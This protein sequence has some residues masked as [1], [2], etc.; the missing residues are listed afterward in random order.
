MSKKSFYYQ[1]IKKIAQV[2]NQTYPIWRTSTIQ[3]LKSFH[4]QQIKNKQENLT[5]LETRARIRLLRNKPFLQQIREQNDYFNI[6]FTPTGDRDEDVEKLRAQIRLRM[7][8]FD[9]YFSIKDDSGHIIRLN[10][11]NIINKNTLQQRDYYNLIVM[12]EQILNNNE[13]YN[14][15]SNYITL[16]IHRVIT[17]NPPLINMRHGKL[18]CAVKCVMDLIKNR[19]ESKNNQIM[20]RHCQKIND[21][22][23]ESG[24]NNEGLQ[25]LADKT[26][27]ILCVMDKTGTVWHEFVPK[28]KGNHQ[29]LLLC[30]HNNH[31]ATILNKIVSDDFCHV[32]GHFH[33][34][35]IGIKLE[36]DSIL[37]SPNTENPISLTSDIENPMPVITDLE[38]PISVITDMENFESG[39]ADSKEENPMWFENHMEN[40]ESLERGTKNL[41]SGKPDSKEEEKDF[42]LGQ[43][44]S[45]FL[46]SFERDSKSTKLNNFVW[47]DTESELLANTLIFEQSNNLGQWIYSKEKPVGYIT[48]D[49]SRIFKVRFPEYE[50]YPEAFTNAGVGKMKFLQQFPE[51]K[52]GNNNDPFYKLM[53]DADVSGFYMRLGQEHDKK[54]N[55]LSSG[56]SDSVSVPL[57]RDT[58]LFEE[59][60]SPS[61]SSVSGKADTETVPL[62][63]DSENLE[64]GYP[65]SKSSVPAF[66]DTENSESGSSDTVLSPFDSAKSNINNNLVGGCPPSKSSVLGLSNTENSELGLSNS[67]NLVS[68]SRGT[69]KYDQNKSYKSFYTSG[70]F[71]GFPRIKA[72][73]NVNKK[74]SE[75]LISLSRGINHGL[76]YIN[77]DELDLSELQ[78]FKA[79]ALNK[80]YYE[81]SG[82]YPIEIVKENYD[83]HG[84]NPDIVEYAYAD[85]V[86]N[87]D[88]SNFTNDQFRTF[89]GKCVSQ[90][91][92]E[93]W[94]T[95]DYYEFMR[96]RYILKDKISTI[97]EKDGIYTVMYKS[98]KAPWNMPIISVYVKAHQKHNIFKQYNKI[99]SSNL[100]KLDSI[101]IV[102]AI[103]VDSIETEIE[104]DHLFNLGKNEGEWKIESDKFVVDSKTRPCQIIDNN[105]KIIVRNK[106]EPSSYTNFGG[107]FLEYTKLPKFL[108][109][110]GAGGNGKSEFIVNLSKSYK[111]IMYIAPTTS[112][113]KNLLDR[114]RILNI[115]IECDT[116]HRVFGVGCLDTFNRDKYDIFV[117]DECSMVGSS[118]LKFMLNKIKPHQSF[119]LSGDFHQLPCID[120]IPINEDDIYKQFEIM[121]LKKNYRQKLDPN[122]FELCNMLR[123]TMTKEEANKF[124]QKINERVLKLP[125]F[126]TLDSAYICG[127]NDQCDKVNNKISPNGLKINDKII[128]NMKCYDNEGI[129]VPNGSI[130]ILL[131]LIPTV[132]IKWNDD[133]ISTFKGIGKTTATKKNRFTLAFSLT[134]HKIQGQTLN[135]NVII[136]PSR[137]FSMNHLYVALTRSTK[138]SNVY[139]TEPITFRILSKTTKIEGI[140]NFIPKLN[141]MKSV[142]NHYIHECSELTEQF[143]TNMR[144]KQDNKCYYCHIPMI[145]KFGAP[146]SIT[147]DRLNDAG[148]HSIDNVVWSC[149]GCNSSHANLG[150]LGKK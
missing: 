1:R 57:S 113:V 61:K 123:K 110:A 108:H 72:I 128:C 44:N 20:I 74:F 35:M 53:M 146:T 49:N 11:M 94:R 133:T 132:K 102:N 75:F 150:Y 134:V 112:A 119:I 80:I 117:L 25:F 54:C 24:I 135:G 23:F 149:F 32:E 147:L 42:E 60:Y 31:M 46:E 148:V 86:F 78:T 91:Y 109:V 126:N 143:L 106:V 118:I 65:P 88:F 27:I 36:K 56:S 92:D 22:Y 131:Q 140:T 85:E 125:D 29:K 12:L 16:H 142:S 10:R 33:R 83:N 76:L 14:I 3:S 89:I 26:K 30:A 129:M 130:G 103:S 141:K 97:S 37:V 15:N 63:R 50:S 145:E 21:K 137:F 38:N 13:D 122:Y 64:G 41:E 82:W 52:K 121:E 5:N 18:N 7:K 87:I 68:L 2:R 58:E 73:F 59:E 6:R 51:F 43:A 34:D 9:Y 45:K 81:Q 69:R 66:P 90:S 124:L 84:I 139:L 93:C 77:W 47:C 120:D 71:T 111:K 96:A 104:C 114:A 79:I 107:N 99:I 19:K 70:I 100:N 17:E 136:D 67:E 127:I 39:K 98:E 95:R 101:I 4:D 48:S 8:N 144:T 105:Y 55:F 115:S 116:Y 40:F 138:F 62:S 28:C